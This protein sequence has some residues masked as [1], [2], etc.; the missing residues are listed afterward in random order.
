[1]KF[2]KVISICVALCSLCYAQDDENGMVKYTIKEYLEANLPPQEGRR[3]VLDEITGLLTITDTPKNHELAKQLIE[4]W[5]VEPKQIQ[6]EAK[7]IEITFTELNEMGMD[8][9]LV[10]SEHPL[11]DLYT[12]MLGTGTSPVFGQASNLAGL[13]LFIGKATMTTGELFAYLK[14]LE[15]TRKANL[16]H[17]PRITTLSGQTANIQV[18]RSFPYATS[19]E[20]K[21]IELEQISPGANQTTK[22]IYAV[23]TYEIDEEIVGISLEVT[24]RV[25]EGSDVITLDI[26]PEVTKLSSQIALTNAGTF[27]S[28]LGWPII[29]TRTS[30]TSVMI[31]SG[32]T[33]IMGGL[34]QDQDS[35]TVERK[36]PILG[37]VPLLGNLFKYK[38]ENRE[39]KN[40]V[41]FLTARLIDKRGKEIR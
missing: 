19:V 20:R 13:G 11:I 16:L 10:S 24:P 27:N 41:I 36:I 15:Q 38:Y 4:E 18:I 33:L 30:V 8:W 40:L 22:D 21:H 31:R 1:M 28:D 29:D 32:E 5:D 14:A 3:I 12:G 6:I 34:I 7:F 25:I 39:K 35:N 2:I 9:R 26:H 17:A 37:D 23:E